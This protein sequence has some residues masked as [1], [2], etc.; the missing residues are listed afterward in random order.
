MLAEVD[1]GMTMAYREIGP[2]DGR[3]VVLLHGFTNDAQFWLDVSSE[4]HRLNPDVR[5]I[6]PDLRGHG[7]STKPTDPTAI[8]IEHMSADVVALLDIIDVQSATFVGHSMGSFVALDIALTHAER[9]E[10]LVLISTSS[11]ATGT[12]ILAEWLRDDV[13][14]DWQS[15]LQARGVNEQDLMSRTPRDVDPSIVV[16]LQKFWNFYPVTPDRPTNG[17]AQRAADLPLATWIGGADAVLGF[18]RDLT[19]LR[20]PTLV[21]W[22]VQDAFFTAADQERLIRAMKQ[23]VEAGSFRWKQ[24]GRKPLPADGLQVDDLGHNLTWEIPAG[25]A[26]DI[27]AWLTT[28]EPSPR[29]WFVAPDG[30]I[31]SLPTGALIRD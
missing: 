17:V 26:E 24:Y 9:V 12:T 29:E 13:L 22:G 2:I 27:N 14:C 30:A 7:A 3:P 18:T 21:L 11:N 8:S 10:T 19:K 31:T 16:W 25:V 23:V 1:T 4:L 5:I 28:G 15:R 20:V 6:M